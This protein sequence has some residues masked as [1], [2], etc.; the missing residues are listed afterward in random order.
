V[1]GGTAEHLYVVSGRDRPVYDI[2]YLEEFDP[3]SATWTTRARMPTGRSGGYGAVLNGRFYVF[4]G[5]GNAASPLGV[6]DNVEGY[7]PASDTWTQYGPMPTP[8]HSLVAAAV[9]NR[10]YLPGGSTQQGTLGAATT[11]LLDAFDPGQ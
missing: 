2:P 6:Y 9:G 4:G 11:L 1:V 8:R 5:E 7:D 10:I 3:R